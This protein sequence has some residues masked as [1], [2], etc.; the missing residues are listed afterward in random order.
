[1]IEVVIR[2]EWIYQIGT[3]P[4]AIL[5]VIGL[6]F[7][8]F[9]KFKKKPL[10]WAITGASVAVLAAFIALTSGFGILQMTRTFDSPFKTPGKYLETSNSSVQEFTIRSDAFNNVLDDELK[11]YETQFFDED[12][13]DTVKYLKDGDPVSFGLQ[14]DDEF[15]NGSM[16]MT[17]EEI[18]IEIYE[19]D[20]NDKTIK[21]PTKEL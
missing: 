6:G 19:I 17:K 5:T 18:V 21:A 7:L 15:I 10:W 1:M 20:G 8:A 12:P 14:S 16:T 11:G 4:F 13:R 2:P 9:A 3:L